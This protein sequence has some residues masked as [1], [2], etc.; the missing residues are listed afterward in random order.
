MF[1][2]CVGFMNPIVQ[3][4]IC[5]TVIPL[6]INLSKN[7]RGV[8]MVHV[9]VSEQ[10]KRIKCQ[11]WSMEE[12]IAFTGSRMYLHACLCAWTLASLGNSWKVFCIQY[13]EVE[14][15][16]GYNWA[17]QK[18]GLSRFNPDRYVGNKEQSASETVHS[19]CSLLLGNHSKCRHLGVWRRVSVLESRGWR[20]V[21]SSSRYSTLLNPHHHSNP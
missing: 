14:Y 15:C 9:C 1:R 17:S 6:G 4:R 8:I 19:A 16:K 5:P 3:V 10:Y 21:W 11:H 7:A 2:G 13:K 20:Q 18:P 12:K